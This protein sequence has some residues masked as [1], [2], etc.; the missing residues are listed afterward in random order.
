MYA[1]AWSHSCIMGSGKAY[2]VLI[3]GGADGANRL[4]LSANDKVFWEGYYDMHRK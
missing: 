3:N 1:N 2:M 4:A